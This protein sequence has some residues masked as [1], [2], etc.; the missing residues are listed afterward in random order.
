MKFLSSSGLHFWHAFSCSSVNDFMS[1]S[2]NLTSL[3]LTT[4]Q[5]VF[6]KVWQ[7]CNAMAQND[8]VN[9]LI[10]EDMKKMPLKSRVEV[11]MNF[12]SGVFSSKALMSI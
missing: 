3:S 10:S 8:V 12:T 6:G 11:S 2:V 4:F 5:P 9:I 1:A 7:P